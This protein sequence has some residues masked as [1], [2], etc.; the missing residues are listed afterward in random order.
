MHVAQVEIYSDA[1]NYVVMKHPGRKF[2][3]SLIQG[4]SLS[5]LCSLADEACAEARSSGSKEAF[6]SMN[7]PRN[8][9]WDRL[10]HYSQV[11]EEHN[12]PLPFNRVP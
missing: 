6:E 1:M 9:L 4:D 7:E 10:N 11:L 12:I 5:V 8:S 2:P 3:G